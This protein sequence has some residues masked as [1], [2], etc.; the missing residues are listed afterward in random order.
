MRTMSE[1]GMAGLLGQ[2]GA[3]RYWPN[4]GNLGDLLIA[5]G[6]R[7]FF[8]R[9]GLAYEE[10]GAL[11]AGEPGTWYALV[12]A[13]G[14]RLTANWRSEEAVAALTD[15][16]VG[17]LVVLPHSINGV[18]GLLAQLGEN[19]HLFCREEFS[20]A[21]C[22]G[23]GTRAHVYLAD[24]M[25]IG[26]DM[27]KL[28]CAPLDLP[29]D[30]LT[31]EELRTR[32]LLAGGLAERMK[33]KVRTA[34][35]PLPGGRGRVAFLLRND[36]EKGT[37][38]QSLFTYDISVEWHTSGRRMRYNGNML[39]VFAEAVRGAD[40]VVT[41]RLHVAIMCWKAGVEVYMIDNSYHKLSGV[42]RKSLAAEPLVHL[43]GDA[44]LPPDL[45]R[46]WRRLNA[47]WR[48]LRRKTGNAVRRVC[49]FLRS[50]AGR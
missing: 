35:A 16:R 34:S 1:N 11:G 2:L 27:G 28:E 47:P 50:M 17:A 4:F 19:A 41:D 5:E 42:Y 33:W 26:L 6:T 20:Y 48:V 15:P 23:S 32:N 37:P 44:T 10:C 21:Y 24:D 43:I 22:A 40:V 12:C 18:D 13:G 30:G 8:A 29:D 46:A 31:P 39:R 14:A 45:L 7:Q 36:S 25:A 9:Y 3:F 38:Y 49:R